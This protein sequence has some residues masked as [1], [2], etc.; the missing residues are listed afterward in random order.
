MMAKR[1]MA[2]S[3][4]ES[5]LAAAALKLLTRKPWDRIT[6]AAVSRAAKVP[7][8]DLLKIAPTRTALAGILLRRSVSETARHYRPERGLPSAH[9]RIF[10]VTMSWFEAQQTHKLATRNFFAGLARDPLTLLALRACI[11]DMA[12][13]LMAL[14]ESDAGPLA[15]PRAIAVGAVIARAIPVWSTDD[16]KLGRTMAQLDR[17]LR[18]LERFL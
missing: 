17:D 3:A 10:D 14:A 4:A 2:S 16:R 5:R 6:L 11:Q 8:D 1:P 15:R 12:E 9:E 7:W 18:R 13:A